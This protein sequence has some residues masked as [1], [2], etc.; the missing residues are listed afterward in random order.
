MPVGYEA[1]L[2]EIL[3][4]NICI[5]KNQMDR[6]IKESKI[7]HDFPL[8]VV[9]GKYYLLE[10]KEKRHKGI[11]Q[12]GIISPL[13]MNWTLDG[14][15]DNIR[16]NA[17]VIDKSYG[18]GE[19]KQTFL[20]KSKL[21]K[22]RKLYP[23]KTEEELLQD[24]ILKVYNKSQTSI[25]ILFYR[26]ADDFIAGTNNEESLINVKKGIESFL[27]ERGLAFSEEKTKTFK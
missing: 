3:K 26:F 9:K 11:P 4:S 27:A 18:K 21:D 1:L 25:S 19:P 2:K 14:L 7:K 12:G 20:D 16:D 13:L 24:K 17:Y 8:E 22:F 5:D 10:S 23:D 6:L 15:Y